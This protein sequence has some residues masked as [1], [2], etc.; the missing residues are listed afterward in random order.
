MRKLRWPILIVILA[1]AAIGILLL[2]RESNLPPVIPEE[3]Q[4]V[5]GGVY[6]EGLVGSF[7]RLNPLLDLYNPSDHDVDRLIFSSLIRFD[8]RG[9]PLGDLAE[10]WGISL[11]GTVYNFSLR[12]E[13]TWHDG[14]PVVSDDI[15]FTVEMMRD[16]ESIIPADVRELWRAVEVVLLDE[17]TIQ[18]RIPEPFA[19]FM[20]YLTFG[21]LPAH[22][23]SGLT[24]A[25]MIDSPFNL[26][27][28]GS[29]PYRLDSLTIE[30]D[31][32]QGLVLKSFQGYYGQLPFIEQ[33]V[34]QYFPDARSALEAYRR[35]EVMGI[36]QIT[37]DIL[38]DALKEPNLRLYTGRLP[39]L[40][41]IFL[42]LDNPEVPFLSD[43]TIRQA[44][45]LGLN[46]QWMIDNLL[47]GQAITA[48]GPVFPNT[49][50]YY[51]GIEHVEYAPDQAIN[52]LKQAGYTIPAEG[53]N[54]RTDQDG[55]AL[56]L[57]LLYPNSENHA[58]L[59]ATIEENWEKLGVEV[60]LR[61]V[62]YQELVEGYLE[63]RLYQAALI[64]LNLTRSPDPD[65]YPFWHQTQI[66]GGQNYSNWDDFQ[67]SEY[68]EQGRVVVDIGERTRNYR[69]FQVRFSQELPALPLF[70]P[71]YVYSVDAE[72]QGVSMGP[73][74]DS[75]DR[76]SLINRWFLVSRR[77]GPELVDETTEQADSEFSLPTGE[78]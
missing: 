19:P 68:L 65:P 77:S 28:I 20:D 62:T 13:A 43:T 69:N 75:S 63:P 10:S 50:A 37:P 41:M 40:S 38:P 36:S 72:V 11:D 70:Y 9:L 74:F 30:G 33:V 12:Q 53:G 78:P 35:D 47:D 57:E 22:L 2:S 39:E 61:P 15:L 18:F 73:L 54:V 67:V 49:W 24:H 55:S 48:D 31:E 23:L 16:D 1:S 14:Q 34:F 42:N 52:L 45:F 32:I 25:E 60:S 6:I 66:T 71:V 8:D 21:I 26:Q 4:P 17:K 46:R 59:A 7:S 56:R 3:V 51:D 76:F 27:P 64:D 58:S 44:L 29:G 5:T